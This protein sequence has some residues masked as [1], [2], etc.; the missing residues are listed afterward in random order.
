MKLWKNPSKKY[1]RLKNSC[2]YSV[3]KQ[4]SFY[5][6]ISILFSFNDVFYYLNILKEN[7]CKLDFA[8]KSNNNPV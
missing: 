8:Y 3:L 1:V 6:Y 4:F 2:V 5:S 7:T